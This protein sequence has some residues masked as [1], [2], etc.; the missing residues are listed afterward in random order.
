VKSFIG[1]VQPDGRVLCASIADD[2]GVAETLALDYATP[3]R[4]TMLASL[5][6]IAG[7]GPTPAQCALGPEP[8]PVMLPDETAFQAQRPEGGFHLFV[9]GAW[10]S[11]SMERVT[12]ASFAIQV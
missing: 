12:G 1:I 7:L 8:E 6:S 4:A 11:W 10:T 5:G 9:D 2:A 3:T